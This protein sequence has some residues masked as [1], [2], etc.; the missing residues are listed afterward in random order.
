MT[1]RRHPIVRARP[2]TIASSSWLALVLVAAAAHAEPARALDEAEFLTRV[3]QADPRFGVVDAR[4]DAARAEIAAVAARPNPSIA[5]DREEVWSGGTGFADHVVAI[6]LPIELSGA[7]GRRVDAARRDADAARAQRDLDRLALR[8]DA[9]EVYYAGTYR[10]LRVEVLRRGRSDLAALVDVVRTRRAAGD[11]SGYDLGRLELE[12]DAYDDA[13]AEA[14]LELAGA[15]RR[16][17]ALI[18]EPGA[19]IDAA[20]ELAVAAPGDP[21]PAAAVR[22]RGDY[23]AAML[24][25]DAAAS[26]LAAADRGWIPRLTLTGGLKTSELADDT[27]IG[28][29]AGLALELPVFD[30][31]QGA[32]ARARARRR[33]ALAE[34]K[35][36]EHETSTAVAIAGDELRRRITQLERYDA[37]AAAK[38]ADLLRRAETAYREGERPITE[39]LDAHRTARD[40]R[41]RQLEIRHAAKQAELAHRRAIGAP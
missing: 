29:V 4:A 32:G 14:E 33:G 34:A 24:R 30:R 36:I 3:E 16:I 9:L 21:P 40:V 5:F 28:Y 1:H 7:R 18:G 8:L 26:E 13:I 20:G 41:L 38:L 15:R 25:A 11:A 2:S 35:V 22:A 31:G 37:G 17:A 39:L 27:A 19:E 6:E 10:R 23:R 12:L